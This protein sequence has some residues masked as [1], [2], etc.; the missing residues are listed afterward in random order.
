MY[1]KP[2][3]LQKLQILSVFLLLKSNCFEFQVF[4]TQQTKSYCSRNFLKNSN[5]QMTEI[6][7]VHTFPSPHAFRYPLAY[8][9]QQI[10]KTTLA[11]IHLPAF[12][13]IYF[14]TKK[15]LRTNNCKVS[16]GLWTHESNNTI[17]IVYACTYH[18]SVRTFID[19]YMGWRKLK[20]VVFLSPLKILHEKQLWTEI[21]SIIHH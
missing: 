20:N 13:F 16:I 7:H 8:M 4:W 18:M 6:C 12:L 10:T 15:L 5:K 2:V 1:K 3:H 21:F 14:I 19:S 11:H 9:T 17:Y